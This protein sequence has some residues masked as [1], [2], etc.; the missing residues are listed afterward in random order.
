MT[1]PA[2]FIGHGSPMNA[3]EVNRFTTMWSEFAQSMERPRAILAIS[4]HWFINAT[5]VTSQSRP[6]IIHDF[7]GFPQEL[8]QFEYPVDGSPDLAKQVAEL[9]EPTW[10]GLDQDSWGI[11]HGTWSVLAHAFPSADVPVVQLA[12][13]AN[14]P[15][16]YHLELG[17]KLAPLMDDGVWIM[18]SGNVVHNLRAIDWNNPEGGFDWAQRFD[19]D[20]RQLMLETP[21]ELG[22]LQ[23]SDDWRLAVPT[24]DHFLPLAYIAGI[25]AAS[26]KSTDVLI[27]GCTM[28]SLSMTAYGVGINHAA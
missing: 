10:V 11:D 24:T 1:I 4:A 21:A 5:A 17:S 26:G 22:A 12:I 2:A 25:A 3:L 13:D 20:A 7:Y 18:A 15:L 23:E 27:D 19:D 28:G 16:A 8:S 14:K 6:R 9:V